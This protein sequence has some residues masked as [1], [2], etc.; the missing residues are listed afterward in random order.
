MDNEKV[1]DL[2]REAKR[3][4]IK[5]FS[6]LR[7]QELFDRIRTA[8]SILDEEIPEIDSPVL[9]STSYMKPQEPPEEKDIKQEIR[10]LEEMLGLRQSSRPKIPEMKITNPEE[11]ERDYCL[12]KDMS[13]LLRSL[14]TK[15]EESVV[16]CLRCLNH[17]PDEEK[18][19]NHEIYCSKKE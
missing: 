4:R 15:H 12:I 3:L 13:R 1:V 8:R 9:R 11:V 16:F 6:R 5:R 18:L 14:V 10:E 2:R 17:F 19:R 7:K